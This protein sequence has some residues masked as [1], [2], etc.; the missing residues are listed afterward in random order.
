[1]LTRKYDLSGRNSNE[2]DRD[3][4]DEDDD[5][6]EDDHDMDGF[7][8]DHE[9]HPS[10]EVTYEQKVLNFEDDGDFQTV[11]VGFSQHSEVHGTINS[12]TLNEFVLK[13]NDT[14]F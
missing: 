5:H 12:F 7:E 6:E 11:A 4:H 9:S 2:K 14:N 10:D 1:V 3:D 13:L 8:D